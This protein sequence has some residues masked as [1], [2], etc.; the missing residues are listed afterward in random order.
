MIDWNKKPTTRINSVLDL[1]GVQVKFTPSSGSSSGAGA[2]TSN[3]SGGGTTINSGSSSGG[4][5]SSGGGANSKKDLLIEAAFPDEPSLEGTYMSDLM[6]HVTVTSA[7]SFPGRININQAS[8]SLLTAV[9]VNVAGLSSDVVDQIISNREAEFSGQNP[10]KKYETWLYT[11]GLVTLEQM[12]QLMPYLTTGG[13]VYRAQ[14]VGYFDEGGTASRVEAIIDTSPLLVASTD[15]TTGPSQGVSGSG[16][17]NTGGGSSQDSSSSSDTS[18][19]TD[20]QPVAA[21]PRIVFWRDMSHL[22]RG[23]TP[24]VLSSAS[25]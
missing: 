9:V 22:G 10:D 14:I 6:D 3:S 5:T 13:S 7:A 24:D 21:V 17:S 23:F 2:T 18:S 16:P 19:T 25:N 15:S 1:V 8:R 11:E 12:K 4:G 20:M